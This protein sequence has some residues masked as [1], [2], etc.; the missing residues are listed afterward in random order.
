MGDRSHMGL[1]NRATFNLFL[2]KCAASVARVWGISELLQ[3]QQ[4]EKSALSCMQIHICFFFLC[5]HNDDQPTKP[6]FRK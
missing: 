5:K 3:Q 2:E 6:V 1:V 4:K